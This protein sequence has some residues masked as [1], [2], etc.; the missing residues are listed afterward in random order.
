MVGLQEFNPSKPDSFSN[1]LTICATRTP[2]LLC[3]QLTSKP[4]FFMGKPTNLDP[5][6]GRLTYRW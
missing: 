6:I 2:G 1:Q 4:A 5:P 3:V